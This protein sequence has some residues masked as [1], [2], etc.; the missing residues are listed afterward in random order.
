MWSVRLRQ[1]AHV[2]RRI[3]ARMS[4][5]I[6]GF[7][8]ERLGDLFD[9]RNRIDVDAPLGELSRRNASVVINVTEKSESIEERT[10]TLRVLVDDERGRDSRRRANAS[11]N[12]RI[13]SSPELRSAVLSSAS[14]A[15]GVLACATRRLSMPAPMTVRG[16]AG[17]VSPDCARSMPRSRRRTAWTDPADR[18]RPRRD[19]RCTTRRLVARNR[20][21]QAGRREPD[22]RPRV[23]DH[24]RMRAR[25][26]SSSRPP[27][28]CRPW[29]PSAPRPARRARR[30]CD[31]PR[32]SSSPCARRA[33]PRCG[34]RSP[35]AQWRAPARAP[36]AIPRRRS[37]GSRRTRACRRAPCGRRRCAGRASRRSPCGVLRSSAS[38]SSTAGAGRASASADAAS[39]KLASAFSASSSPFTVQLI[40]WR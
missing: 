9:R 23:R 19:P 30:G 20:I 12:S 16:R 6:A 36:R 33:A 25:R 3:R 17:C 35:P 7:G 40:G 22:Q 8:C 18:L 37:R 4:P 27:R 1:H 34:G 38:A 11:T 32:R 15:S 10:A 29:N 31:R 14:A 5:I 28:S 26:A 21:Q 39:K 13:A 2:G 24:D